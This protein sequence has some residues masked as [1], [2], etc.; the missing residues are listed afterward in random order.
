MKS[1]KYPSIILAFLLVFSLITPYSA[2]FAEG[3]KETDSDKEAEVELSVENQENVEQPKI[4]K[5]QVIKE[6]NEETK[7][8]IKRQDEKGLEE[9]SEDREKN[10]ESKKESKQEE[11]KEKQDK[12][13]LE[14]KSEDKE[15]KVETQK[16][17]KQKDKKKITPMSAGF[18]LDMW[19]TPEEV[20]SG[21]T[22]TYEVEYGF[23]SVQETF[24]HSVIEIQLP[25]EIEFNEGVGLTEHIESYH[26]DEETHKLTFTFKE[27]IEG[28][29]H[30]IVSF[31]A[32]FPNY[33]TPNGTEAT[34]AADL[35][36]DSEL[37]AN[38]RP[39]NDDSNS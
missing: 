4:D 37:K 22:F 15:K 7:E 32:K 29:S 3:N 14:E 11:A 34:V 28:G 27:N 16:Q 5:Q 23:R 30:G 21:E 10:V 26:Y 8:V 13:E 31:K 39:S 38:I 18:F 12:K 9:K 20:R 35:I 2:V 25:D 36:V 24:K 6:S 33:V 17:S 1:Q 19:S